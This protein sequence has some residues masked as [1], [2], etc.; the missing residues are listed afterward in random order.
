MNM[1]IL[2]SL[3]IPFAGTILGASFLFVMKEQL[4]EKWN[5]AFIGFASGVMVAASVWSLL[6]P[7]LETSSM[8]KLSFIPAVSGFWIG[9][10]FL[11]LLDI[12]VPHLHM[13]ALQAEGRKSNFSKTTKMILAVA[14]HNIPEGIAVGVIYAGYLSGHTQ[15]SFMSA[16]ALSIGIA[17]QNIPEGAIVSIPLLKQGHTKTK[18][19]TIGMLSGI[20]EPVAAMITLFLSE[21]LLPVLPYLLSFAAGTMFYVVI[22]ELI[23]EM[24]QG[25]HSN[26][27]TIF[28]AIGFSL[29]MILD[30]VL[31]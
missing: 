5:R 6:I 10:L 1:E 13:N 7:S 31:A 26:I 22:E 3:M 29:M 4:G 18:A 27:G 20:V 2:I 12:I 15:I 8:G 9:I 23:P 28:F 19:F 11:F 14:L 30:I 25:T 24:S 17:I 21:L 16:L